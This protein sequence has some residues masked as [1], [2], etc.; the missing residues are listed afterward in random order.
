MLFKH[1]DKAAANT[2]SK[3]ATIGGIEN[4]RMV[5]KGTTV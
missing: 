2:F 5:R 4:A 3:Q 1:R